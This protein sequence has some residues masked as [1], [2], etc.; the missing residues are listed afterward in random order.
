MT[1]DYYSAIGNDFSWGLGR[2][3]SIKSLT[4]QS[5]N[6]YRRRHSVCHSAISQVISI[7]RLD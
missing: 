1:K 7:F 5:A 3:A 6:P 2:S 4:I